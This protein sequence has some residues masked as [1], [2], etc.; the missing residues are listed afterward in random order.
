MEVEEHRLLG[1]RNAESAASARS[2]IIIVA[3]GNMLALAILIV[4]SVVLRLDIAR[5]LQA[6]KALRSSEQRYRS[7]F[8]HNLAAVYLASLEGVIQDCNQAFVHL[9]GGFSRQDVL[10]QRTTDYYVQ[11]RD[12]EA[13][14]EDLRRGRQSNRPRDLLPPHRWQPGLGARNRRTS[15]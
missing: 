14:V 13:L 6:E 9:A 15:R 3:F 10:G 7:L 5:R 8:E 11:T 12:R 2:T 4:A 1:Q